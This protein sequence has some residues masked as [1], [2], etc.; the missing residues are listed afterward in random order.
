MQAS[1]LDICVE[2]YLNL[3]NHDDPLEKL[4]AIYEKF[5]YESERKNKHNELLI[6]S[7]VIYLP[8]LLLN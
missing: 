5:F 3:E 2:N 7:F 8:I 6:S 4:E 1:D